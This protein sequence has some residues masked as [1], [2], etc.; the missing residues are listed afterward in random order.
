MS[1]VQAR[2]LRYRRTNM[3][4][5]TNKSH[6]IA[7]AFFLDIHQAFSDEKTVREIACD[8]CSIVLDKLKERYGNDKID[9]CALAAYML[10]SNILRLKGAA[11]L[12]LPDLVRWQKINIGEGII[13]RVAQN[14][15]PLFVNDVA[16]DANVIKGLELDIARHAGRV[17]LLA[18]PLLL[19]S[20]NLAGV[21]IL[22]KFNPES[23]SEQFFLSPQFLETVKEFSKQ[24]ATIHNHAVTLVKAWLSKKYTTNERHF[25]SIIKSFY[26]HAARTIDVRKFMDCIAGELMKILNAGNMEMPYYRN[27]L[28]Y[29]YQSYRGRYILR[30]YLRKPHYFVPSIPLNSPLYKGYIEDGLIKSVES[31]IAF[32][33][34]R[35]REPHIIRRLSQKVEEIVERLDDDWSPCGR[36]SA[37]IVPL[38]DGQS[39]LGVLVFLSRH[40]NRQ[41]ING[42]LFYLGKEKRQTSLYDLRVF[43]SLQPLIAN[44]YFKLRVDEERQRDIHDLESILSAMKEIILLEDQTEVLDRLAKFTAQSLSCDGC[45]IYLMNRGKTQLELAAASGFQIEKEFKEHLIFPLRPAADQRRGLPVQVFEKRNSIVANRARDFRRIC[46]TQKKFTPFFRQLKS[47]RVMSYL[48]LPIGELGVIEVFNK[49]KLTPTAWSF[50]EDQDCI[51]LRHIADAIA[52]VLKRMEATASQVHSEK[53]KVTSELLLDISHELKNPLY[54][55]LIFVRKLKA[56]LNGQLASTDENGTLQTISLIERNVEKAQRILAGMQNFQTSMTQMKREP[57]NLK[58]IL[59]MVMQTNELLCEQQRITVGSEFLADEPMVC[60]DELQLNQVFTNLFKNAMDAMPNGGMLQV[61]LHEVEENLQVEIADTGSGIPNEIKD[62]VFEP[63]VTTKNSD[64]GTGL[65]LALCQRLIQQHHGKIEFE[66]ELNW[67]TKFFVT[68]P[69]FVEQ[70]FSPIKQ[71]LITPPLPS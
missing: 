17:A 2:A 60:G 32:V 14:K 50:F 22:G 13:G 27:Y 36:G 15:K 23:T 11:G 20:G 28:F 34:N 18:Y 49:S 48:G 12:Q 41:Y 62:R 47:G 40:Q 46:G 65:G 58:K 67:G 42:P 29:E 68:L 45:L 61:C 44:A 64:N 39:P 33:K 54:A 19:P 4:D 70:T 31:Q 21:L 51:T 38:A 9:L 5:E 59:R 37:F 8:I 25:A 3:A 24:I 6:S 26:Q 63:F 56:A 53:V 43:R 66:T 30:S 57:V 16:K 35:G 55:S 7:S 71:L 69:K 52:T 10:N 1:N